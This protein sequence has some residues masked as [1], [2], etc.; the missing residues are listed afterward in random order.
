[1]NIVVENGHGENSYEVVKEIIRLGLLPHEW[2]ANEIPLGV[3]INDAD[4]HLFVINGELEIET[5]GVPI[6]A[7]PGAY[8]HIS[9]G[10][11]HQLIPHENARVYIGGY[12][13]N[14]L[15]P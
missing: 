12:T 13:K 15:F 14:K 9:A 6:S 11:A 3:R 1:M 10:T 8:V 5:Y 7:H 4:L 2:R